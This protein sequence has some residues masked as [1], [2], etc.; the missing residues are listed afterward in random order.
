MS[1]TKENR[2]EY[3]PEGEK[4]QSTIAA[5][6]GITLPL[7]LA[8]MT[9]AILKSWLIPGLAL[10]GY[11]AWRMFAKQKRPH[12]ILTVDGDTL[13]VTDGRGRPLLEVSLDELESV[14]LD[15]KT[16]ERVQENMG[17]LP[18]VRFI[19]ATV[20]P[21][22]DTARIELSTQDETITLTERYTSSIDAT[23]WLSKIRRFLRSHGWLPL[24]EREAPKPKKK[25][26]RRKAKASS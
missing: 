10:A 25:K 18:E 3:F 20:G 13:S 19:N 9:A 4:A 22:I 24:A 7:L 6:M 12:R 15:V 8:A 16:I 23:D 21:S 11:V 5:A 2:I 26:R 14:V 1:K 17:G